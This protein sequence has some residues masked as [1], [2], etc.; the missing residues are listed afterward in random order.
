MSIVYRCDICGKTNVMSGVEF[1]NAPVITTLT[2]FNGRRFRLILNVSTENLEDNE[3]KKEAAKDLEEGNPDGIQ[4]HPTIPGAAIVFKK[5]NITT[6][7]PLVCD[8]CKVTA[9]INAEKKSFYVDRTGAKRILTPP[10][11]SKGVDMFIQRAASGEEIADAVET[12]DSDL[13]NL[14]KHSLQAGMEEKC[15]DAEDLEG[16]EDEGL[17]SDDDEA[18]D[19]QS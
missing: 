9:I 16:E 17:E 18:A 15:L 8:Q 1:S 2:N 10:D 4:P 6:P 12:I 11:S 14:L 7:M 19:L 13:A 3:K 5:V